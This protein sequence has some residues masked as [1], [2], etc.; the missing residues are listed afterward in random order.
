MK[1]LSSTRDFR[2]MFSRC[3]IDDRIAL[4]QPTTRA[5]IAVGKRQTRPA[6]PNR[7]N[8]IRF[9]DQ[10]SS[11]SEAAKGPSSAAARVQFLASTRADRSLLTPSCFREDKVDWAGSGVRGVC[12]SILLRG[13]PS[14]CS[15]I[16]VQ[17][18]PTVSLLSQV[19]QNC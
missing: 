5:S 16:E 2:E 9:R 14:C 11:L 1:D 17:R 10:A 13:A 18:L 15:Y 4:Q 3:V 7:N 6:K 8:A 19:A 12:L